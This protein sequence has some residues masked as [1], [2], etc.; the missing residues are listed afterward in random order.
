MNDFSKVYSVEELKK[1]GIVTLV[2][3]PMEESILIPVAQIIDLMKRG[4]NVVFFTFNH[5]SIKVHDF[6]VPA[7][8]VEPNPESITGELAII[9]I[10]QVPDGVELIDFVQDKV[11][12]IQSIYKRE[13]KSINFVFIDFPKDVLESNSTY[14]L[15]KKVKFQTNVASILV[16]TLEMPVMI[17]SQNPASEKELKEQMDEFI[18]KD[19]LNS[20]RQESNKILTESDYIIGVQRKKETFWKKVVDFLLFWRKRSN[21]TLKIIKN[22]V[23]PDSKSFRMNVDLDEFRAE[24]L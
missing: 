1:N 6:L 23:G 8:K 15:L 5:D 3:L 2:T 10:H 20:L 4:E 21:F 24:I 17:N 12:N 9:D 13:G 7:L 22:R 18:D 16:K 11:Y 14:D 19:M